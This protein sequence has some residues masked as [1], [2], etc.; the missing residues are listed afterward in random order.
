[1]KKIILSL[2]AF[3]VFFQTAFSQTVLDSKIHKKVTN[4]VFE[5]V[6]NK[7]EDD[8]I[9]YEE[10]LPLDRLPYNVRNDKFYSIG[11]AFLLEDG[12]FYSASHVF[13]LY[14]DTIQNEY[15]IRD[16]EGKVYPVEDIVY[17][18]NRRDFI[19][20][21]VPSYKQRKGQGLKTCTTTKIN[22]NVYSVGNALGDGVVIRNGIFTSLT[23]EDRDGEWKWIRFSAAASPGNSG[24]PLVNENGEVIGIITMKSQNENL[25]YAL[26]IEELETGKD[27]IGIIDYTYY[28]RLPNLI[29]KKQYYKFEYK[30]NLPV[31]YTELHKELTEKYKKNIQEAVAVMRKDYQPSAPKSFDKA[32]GN[33]EFFF[34]TYNT[35]FPCT[36]YLSDSNVWDYGGTNTKSFDIEDNGSVEYCS[37]FNYILATIDKP[38]SMSLEDFL[39]NPKTYIDYVIEATD[40]H[41][42]VASEN[43]RISS[44][45]DPTKVEQYVDFFGRTWTASYFDINFADAVLICYALPLPNGVYLMYQTTSRDEAFACTY[46]D[47]QFVADF[48]YTSYYGKAKDW[49]DFLKLPESIIGKKPTFLKQIKFNYDKTHLALSVGDFSTDIPSSIME[50]N[51]ETRIYVSNSFTTKNGKLEIENRVISIYTDP[52]AEEYKSIFIKKTNKPLKNAVKKTQTTWEQLLKELSPFD[53]SPYNHEQYTYLDRIQFIDKENKNP[54]YIY[55]LCFEMKKDMFEE[56]KTFADSVIENTKF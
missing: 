43:I 21:T 32:K 20:F 22:S 4:A 30:I 34:N 7:T 38:E 37:I 35:S 39:K 33:A 48:T 31:K 54:D 26:P 42:T 46:L 40:L 18:S 55:T 52:K 45:G 15:Y 9:T 8:K 44:L 3:L 17:L 53:G 5:V 29:S 47:M 25:N 13:S 51:D 12:I 24:G 16:A 10:E 28:Y 50:I 36:I 23:D 1:M 56:I 2:V 6:V 27:G 11:T 14:G 41:R 49:A 19:G